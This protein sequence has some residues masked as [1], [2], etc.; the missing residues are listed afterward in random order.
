M[1]H[2]V[3]R[4]SLR[5]LG[6]ASAL[7]VLA[8]V[9]WRSIG[10]TTP[11]ASDA[12]FEALDRTIPEHEGSSPTLL[13]APVPASRPA[14][15]VG[16]PIATASAVTMGAK[17]YT[18][19]VVSD[20]DG[21]SVGDATIES[22]SGTPLGK[23]DAAGNLTVRFRLPRV[24][25]DTGVLVRHAG[26]AVEFVSPRLGDTTDVRLTRGLP[27]RGR[28]VLAATG[29]PVAGARVATLDFLGHR[30]ADEVTTDADGRFRVDDARPGTLVEL[31]VRAPGRATVTVAATPTPSSAEFLVRLP[32][33][34]TLSGWVR[35]ASGRPLPGVPI[36][37]R[38]ETGA[39]HV[40]TAT[41]L[42]PWARVADAATDASGRYEVAGIE[43]EDRLVAVAQPRPFLVAASE[44]F[45]LERTGDRIEREIRVPGGGTLKVTVEGLPAECEARV[46]LLGARLQAHVLDA[47]RTSRTSWAIQEVT[48]GRY[49][50]G[51]AVAGFPISVKAIEVVSGSVAHLTFAFRGSLAVE[52]RVSYPD[53]RPAVGARIWWRGVTGAVAVADEIGAFQFGGLDASA[54]R[55]VVVPPDGIPG[56]AR[57]FLDGVRPGGDPLR[58]VLGLLP[59]V[60]LL[61]V[62][63]P[64]GAHVS[65][66]V[67]SSVYRGDASPS[68]AADGVVEVT[69][70]H[71]GHPTRITWWAEDCGPVVTEVP[72]LAAGQVLDLGS[73]RFEEGRSVVLRIVDGDDRPVPGARVT[74]VSYWG[75]TQSG[76][77]SDARGDASLSR[78]P[79]FPFLVSVTAEGRA[80]HLLQVP[81]ETS[82]PVVL[83]LGAEGTLELR[84]TDREGA[85]AAKANTQLLPAELDPYDPTPEG[86]PEGV[87]TDDAGTL[88]QRVQAGTHRVRVFPAT[89]EGETTTGPVVVR[90][91]ETTTL[92]VRLP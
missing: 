73:R 26:F 7:L 1:L 39:L 52:G 70:D 34:G 59:R 37:L 3:S 85:P 80:P 11:R 64:A 91:G 61:P 40:S 62:G 5:A 12:Q 32:E 25:G 63:L 92:E 82:G 78:M 35:D 38:P 51:L 6:I 69:V 48:P 27:I 58:V 9:A 33:G 75:V 30:I 8:F 10:S 77:T 45:K 36:F 29:D 17:T 65:A 81:A 2:G 55:L 90:A 67:E 13:G 4:S 42:P 54:G 31:G 71:V 79:I 23:T 68:V 83:R 56:F 74:L 86:M 46:S 53:G 76:V 16:E 57:S 50:V 21:S 24:V 18:F 22:R 41:V 60:R 44:P 43:T 88:T 72:A 89:R 14:T 19:H 20:A 49:E 15:T 84:V 87:P 28:V 66:C 47:E